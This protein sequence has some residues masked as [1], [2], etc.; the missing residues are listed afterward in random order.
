MNVK[1]E[2]FK[3]A[4]N[5]IPNYIRIFVWLQIAIRLLIALVLYLNQSTFF[6]DLNFSEEGVLAGFD[7][8]G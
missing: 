2:A 7:M 4:H 3:D 8:A 1:L 5:T 6:T